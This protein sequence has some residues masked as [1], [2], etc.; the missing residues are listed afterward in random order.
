[1]WFIYIINASDELKDFNPN[2]TKLNDEFRN[3][4]NSYDRQTVDEKYAK[5]EQRAS[6]MNI[7]TGKLIF[8]SSAILTFIFGTFFI[9]I[10]MRLRHKS[11]INIVIAQAD[12]TELVTLNSKTEN[13]TPIRKTPS[14]TVCTASGSS[15][16]RN[17]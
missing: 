10:G 6:T 17:R 8:G 5:D 12:P 7:T 4:S 14:K 11:S 13:A 16:E 9:I 15:K 2:L 1:M 3:Q